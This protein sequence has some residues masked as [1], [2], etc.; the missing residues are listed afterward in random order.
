MNASYGRLQ[1]AADVLSDLERIRIMNENR[2]RQLTRSEEDSDGGHR[3]F[4][5]GIDQPDVQRLA[6]LVRQ[7]RCDSAL[8][9]DLTGERPGKHAGCCLEHEAE[10]NLEKTLAG[11]P[12][13][14]FA[15]TITGLGAKQ[16]GR[17][18]GATGDPYL[19]TAVY[20]DDGSLMPGTGCPRTLS[21]WHAYCGHGDPE[22]RRR[23]GMTQDEAR[24]LGKP[25]AKMRTRLIAEQFIRYTG[26]PDQ[27]GKPTPH[28]PY[29]E[30]YQTARL[31]YETRV[32]ERECLNSSRISPNGCGTRD[33]P[34]WGS[35]GSPWRPGHQHA[36]ALRL[37]G[38]QFLDDLYAEAKRL[39]E[40][41]P[42]A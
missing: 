27:N 16:F 7:M 11:V 22:R 9:A 30:I 15:S 21:Q 38:K 5:L 34:E 1:M 20:L 6:A 36:A 2:L 35:L 3:G 19:R 41:G 12:L 29:Y 8:V 14:A 33:H 18:L 10:R 42:A 40:T 39:H 37:T 23:K 24:A 4:G 26:K 13:G 28:S 17:L 25:D 31:E 32:H